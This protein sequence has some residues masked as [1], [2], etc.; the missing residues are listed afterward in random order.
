MFKDKLD[1]NQSLLD[2]DISEKVVQQ[3]LSKFMED[4]SP[5]TDLVQLLFKKM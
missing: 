3:K 4:K 5:G 2:T 1:E